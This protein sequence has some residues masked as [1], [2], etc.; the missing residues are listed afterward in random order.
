MRSRQIRAHI[1]N[2]A[3]NIGLEAA[4]AAMT[5]DS[6]GPCRAQSGR[7]TARRDYSD[8]L[9]RARPVAAGPQEE[10][11]GHR[12][13]GGSLQQITAAPAGR[14]DQDSDS[15]EIRRIAGDSQTRFDSAQGGGDAPVAR[16]RRMRRLRSSLP[17]W[18]ARYVSA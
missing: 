11:A 13:F 14:D 1:A 2:G 6:H 12:G 3:A 7:I 10:A 4:A 9:R 5:S 15:P 8:A 18:C 17:L 16:A